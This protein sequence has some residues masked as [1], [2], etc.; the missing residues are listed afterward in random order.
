MQN[1]SQVI[2]GEALSRDFNRRAKTARF[3]L[4]RAA[5]AAVAA[6][7]SLRG[8]RIAL[9]ADAADSVN[10]NATAALDTPSNYSTGLL[11]TN[12][13]DMEF[14]SGTY[15]NTSFTLNSTALNPATLDD[16]DAT[17][18]LTITGNK[19]ITLQGGTNGLSGTAADALYVVG[20][21]NLTLAGTGGL[22]LSSTGN[23]DIAGNATINAVISG[24]NL[25]FTQTGGGTLTL[26]NIN[27]Y[28]GGTTVSSGTLRL[29]TAVKQERS[30]ATSQLTPE[31]RCFCWPITPWVGAAPV[32]S[33]SPPFMSTVGP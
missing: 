30:M 19:S 15:G 21:G 24:S 23:F 16:L 9:A 2:D 13:Q 10:T 18:A 1:H 6:V 4:S 17:Q 12:V 25:G 28:T 8:A 26:S 33:M 32:D 5:V 20:G 22:A 27:T 14:L 3:R 7:A 11:P 31:P 29:L